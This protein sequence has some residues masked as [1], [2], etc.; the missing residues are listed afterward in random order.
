MKHLR[1][2]LASSFLIVFLTLIFPLSSASMG[3][4]SGS[5]AATATTTHLNNKFVR[6]NVLNPQGG[7]LPSNYYTA[8]QLVSLVSSIHQAVGNF[9][10]VG[11]IQGAGNQGTPNPNATGFSDWSGNLDSFVTALKA[12]SGG[13]IIAEGNLDVYFGAAD[14]CSNPQ[15]PPPECPASP[16]TFFQDTASLLKFSAVADGERYLM[17]GS[18]APG[19][20]Y[21]YANPNKGFIQNFFQN[22]TNQ[23]WRHFIIET[24]P[25]KSDK[26]FQAYDYGNAQYA[27]MGLFFDSSS[28]SYFNFNQ[29][30]VASMQAQEPYI[31][32]LAAIAT[33]PLGG[34]SGIGQ[35]VNLSPAQQ[36]TALTDLAGN[37]AIDSYVF[38]YPVLVSQGGLSYNPV[39]DAN[40]V[41]QPNG[42]S[43]LNLITNL[44]N[45]YNSLPL[46]TATST[47]TA[48]A[49][50]TAT[51][52]PSSSSY[53]T[54]ETTS[55]SPAIPWLGGYELAFSVLVGLAVLALRRRKHGG[56]Q[57]SSNDLTK[58]RNSS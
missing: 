11:V 49:P 42:Q 43:F 26:R 51:F 40:K 10:L 33:Q 47:A 57:A 46:S 24:S 22:L 58:S 34:T 41:L 7:Y 9:N 13:E 29:A 39:W 56:K 30:Y 55:T 18:W 8:T 36:V 4:A 3:Y 54:S 37:Q 25:S 32:E 12:A 27:K 2:P 1:L 14:M 38:I 5:A 16:A 6:I 48:M 31:N 53:A 20:F 23:G 28:P 19:A 15:P 17:L 52:T 50:S 44:M 21:P 35:F 45:Q